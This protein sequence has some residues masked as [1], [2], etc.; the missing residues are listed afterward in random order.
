MAMRNIQ[1]TIRKLLALARSSQYPGERAAARQKAQEL[2]RR[3]GT[4]SHSTRRDAKQQ[5]AKIIAY[6]WFNGQFYPVDH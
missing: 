5:V 2:S 3:H 6:D 4:E 1:V